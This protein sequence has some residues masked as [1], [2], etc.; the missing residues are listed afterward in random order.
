MLIFRYFTECIWHLALIIILNIF[1][2]SFRSSRC[3]IFYK[4]AV[5][6][7]VLN[8]LKYACETVLFLLKLQAI[9][10]Q[11]YWSRPFPL[12][13]FKRFWSYNQLDTLQNSYFEEYL[14]LQNT[15]NGC[16]CSFIKLQ[17][18]MHTLS[19]IEPLASNC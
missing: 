15:F 14:F 13:F 7:Q 6:N 12:V 16:F 5:L 8:K 2:Y 17:W 1:F 18:L 11:L 10:L 9:A 3:E 19:P 4:I